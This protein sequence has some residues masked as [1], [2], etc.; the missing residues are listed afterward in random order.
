MKNNNWDN[1]LKYITSTYQSDIK[2]IQFIKNKI[3]FG[4]KVN[5][6]INYK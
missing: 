4:D 1:L 5:N 6:D 3:V 2:V